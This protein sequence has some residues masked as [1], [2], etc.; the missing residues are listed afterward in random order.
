[1]NTISYCI[2]ILLIFLLFCII[3]KS[4]KKIDIIPMAIITFLCILAYQVLIC[5]LLSIIGIPIN[6]KNLSIVNLFF[7]ISLIIL[8]KQK[9]YKNF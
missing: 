4:E 1:M 3:K 5:W 9:D 2:S 8:L 7:S 6:L